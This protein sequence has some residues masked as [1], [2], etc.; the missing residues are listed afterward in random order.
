MYAREGVTGERD[1]SSIGF[2]TIRGGSI[3]GDH[4]VLFAGTG[5]RIEITHKSDTRANYAQGSLRA[6]RFLADQASGLFSMNDV[7]GLMMNGLPILAAGDATRAGAAL[8]LLMSISGGADLLEKLAAARVRADI[9]RAVRRLSA[10]SLK[11]RSH[12]RIR[13]EGG[14]ALLAAATSSPPGARW[15][16][17]PRSQLTRRLRD[18]LHR[19]PRSW[20]SAVVLASIGSTAPFIGLFARLGHYHAAGISAAGTS[21]RPRLR[22][23]G[24]ALVMT[25]AAWPWPSGVLLTTCQQ[26]VAACEASWKLCQDLREMLADAPPPTQADWRSAASSAARRP[27]R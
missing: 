9:A 23:G 12:L 2:A 1:P 17:R 16:T 15:N 19:V 27:R 26:A 10:A 8:L 13:R 6:V 5:E 21:H 3:I 4:T 22:P 7:L 25:A 24:E 11:A 14:C 20:H 18:A